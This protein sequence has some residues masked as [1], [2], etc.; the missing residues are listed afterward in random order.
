MKF[1][2][3]LS[4]CFSSINHRTAL[5][6]CTVCSSW[7]SILLGYCTVM[8]FASGN[9]HSEH[10]AAARLITQQYRRILTLSWSRDPW[11]RIPIWPGARRIH[12]SLLVDVLCS[13]LYT[14]YGTLAEAVFIFLDKTKADVVCYASPRNIARHKCG[15]VMRP[16]ESVLTQKVYFRYANKTS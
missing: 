9:H 7:L 5:V 10:A 16:A 14:C 11:P 15:V 1:I 13:I 12:L 4:T 8:W 2:A 3:S 6:L